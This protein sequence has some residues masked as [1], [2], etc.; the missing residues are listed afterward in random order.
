MNMS[1]QKGFGLIEVLVAVLVLA[2]GL[3]GLAG[4]QTQ[5]LRFNNEAYFRTQATLLAMDMADRLRSNLETARATPGSYTFSN[6]DA[7]PNSVTDCT[8]DACTPSQLAQYDFKEWKERA[9]TL[10]PGA[11][12]ALTPDSVGIGQGYTIQIEYSS[13]ESSGLQL[14]Q[15]RVKI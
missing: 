15:Y 12:V 1:H 14:F 6:T 10:L 2:V 3:L 9:Q 8:S 11:Q 5:S 13:T 7:V 4:L